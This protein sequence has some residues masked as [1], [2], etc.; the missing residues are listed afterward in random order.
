[1]GRLGL[2]CSLFNPQRSSAI[3]LAIE[4]YQSSSGAPRAQ[5]WGRVHDPSPDTFSNMT[6]K[7]SK[8]KY[9]RSAKGRAT[10]AAY[11]ARSIEARKQNTR[12]WRLKRKAEV[13]AKYGGK[14]VCCGETILAFLTI[15][16]I[17]GNGRTERRLNNA[18]GNKWYSQLWKAPV[19]TDLEI[20]CF[21]CN[22]GK[23]VN[24][25]VCPHAE[26]L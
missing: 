13:I 25:G 20:R 3:A 23:Q 5:L 17:D 22:C 9:R 12:Q 19:R 15:D 21:N 16:H 18:I 4:R 7:E 26:G 11:L 2:I 24:G 6:R 14:C 1:M 8:D 10:Q